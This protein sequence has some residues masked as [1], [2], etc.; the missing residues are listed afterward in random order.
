MPEQRFSLAAETYDKHAFPQ[1][2]LAKQIISFLPKTQPDRLLELGAGTGQ[3]TR[4]LVAQFPHSSIDV[5]DL[6]EKMIEYGRALFSNVSCL[7]WQVADAETFQATKAYP[8]IISSSALHWVKDL[9]KTFKTIFNNLEDDGVFVFGLMLKDTL[10]ELQTIRKEV[11]PKK[12]QTH[13]LPT[14]EEVI[15]A[16]KSVGFSIDQ[17][18]HRIDTFTYPSATQFLQAIHEQGVT[19]GKT[20]RDTAPLSRQELQKLIQIYQARFSTDQGVEAS[21][22]TLSI[23]ARKT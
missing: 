21:Y 3:L 13:F 19:G 2:K 16:L 12:A 20:S 23:R 18:R 17:T 10:I 8:L 1:Q 5:I 14:S 7:H 4:L 9:T 11:A 22:E 15:T 6:S